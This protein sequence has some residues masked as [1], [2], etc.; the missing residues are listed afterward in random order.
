MKKFDTK[1]FYDSKNSRVCRLVT[2][3]VFSE[4]GSFV[5]VNLRNLDTFEVHC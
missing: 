1:L 4:T 5:V 2:V 3:P